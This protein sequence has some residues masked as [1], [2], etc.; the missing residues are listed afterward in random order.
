MKVYRK[1]KIIVKVMEMAMK[2]G[3]AATGALNRL[4]VF[5]GRTDVSATDINIKP[6][7]H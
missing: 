3:V 5:P 2:T 4:G 1:K 6:T 7:R